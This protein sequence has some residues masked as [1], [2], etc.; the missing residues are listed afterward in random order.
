[1]VHVPAPRP[2]T[3]VPATEHVA[4]VVLAKVT[5]L[6]EGPP[7]ALTVPVVPTATPDGAVPKTIAWAPLAT[8]TLTV[9]VVNAPMEAMTV[10]KNAF[11]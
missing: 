6:P 10:G 7:L 8:V 9:N 11:T 5:G 2:V 3:V 4:G 1:M